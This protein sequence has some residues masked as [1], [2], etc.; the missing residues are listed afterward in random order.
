MAKQ[1]KARARELGGKDLSSGA[2]VGSSAGF[3]LSGADLSAGSGARS[4]VDLGSG[5]GADLGTNLETQGSMARADLSAGSGVDLSGGKDLGSRSNV[6]LNA[7]SGARAEADL[8]AQSTNGGALY[9]ALIFFAVLCSVVAIDQYV[10]DL[11]LQGLRWDSPCISIVLVFNKGVAFSLFSFL[12]QNVKFLQITF[13]LIFIA[14]AFYN[15][16]FPVYYLPFAIIIGGGVSNI[17]DRFFHVGVVDYVYW[18]CGFDFAVFN[19]ADALIDLGIAI[20]FLQ[21]FL[22]KRHA[23]T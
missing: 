9:K 10:K 5:S 21:Y 8:N 11:I 6:D 19:L 23:E 20:I 1:D 7:G 3:G 16:L 17:I 14:T 12:E 18:H 13:L 4:G 22:Q 2:G 15:K